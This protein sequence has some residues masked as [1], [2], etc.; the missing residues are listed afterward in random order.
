MA[1]FSLNLNDANITLFDGEKIVYREPGF[2]SIKNDEI[3]CGIPAYENWRLDPRRTY[4]KFWMD[5][6]TKAIPEER[7]SHLCPGDLASFQIENIWRKHG[8]G[9]KELIVIVP[10][11]MTVDNLGLFLGIAD[12]LDL[13][14]VSLIDAAVAATRRQ[15]KDALLI[16]ID[17]GLHLA[18]VSRL[19]QVGM[20]QIDRYEIIQDTGLLKLYECWVRKIGKNFVAQSRFDPLHSAE[21][22][23][24]LFN[25]LLDWLHEASLNKLVN[26]KIE[27]LGEEYSASI[28]LKELIDVALPIYNQMISAFRSLCRTKKNVAI[29]ITDRVAKMPGLVD[30][31]ESIVGGQV[32]VLESGASLRGAYSRGL[33][34]QEDIVLTRKL[35]WDQS[36]IE[37]NRTIQ[38]RAQELVGVPSHLLHDNKAIKINNTPIFIGSEYIHDIRSIKISSEIKGVSRKHCSL[39]LEDNQCILKDHSRYGTFLNGHKVDGSAILRIGDILTLGTPEKVFYLIVEED[40]CG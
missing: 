26:M 30:L 22:E 34:P 29:Q 13:P 16:H 32:F 25:R 40:S 28:E 15:Y 1:R 35:S 9:V 36:A 37:V 18:Y 3:F 8:S 11:N 12:D 21:L 20:T 6:S 19:S 33:I 2:A 10:Q 31:L 14:V 4:H 39:F 38:K 17:L 7:F 27:Y 5:L 24:L 23:Q